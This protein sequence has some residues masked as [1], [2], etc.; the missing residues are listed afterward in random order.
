MQLYWG[1]RKQRDLYLIELPQKWTARA[2]WLS[3]TPVLS[4][5]EGEWHGRT[6]LVHQAVLDDHA[7]LSDAELYACG[8]PLMI[9]AAQNSFVTARGLPTNHFYSD[10]FVPS[11]PAE[12]PDEG[13]R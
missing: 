4:E 9:A 7:D 1:A 10:A 11:G 6:G 13:G 3:F 12:Q 2:P 8:N 5:P